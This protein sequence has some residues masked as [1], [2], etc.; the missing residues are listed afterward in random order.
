[1]FHSLLCNDVL[2]ANSCARR[3]KRSRR[4]NS[5]GSVL[6]PELSAFLGTNSMPRTQ[7]VKAMWD[8]IKKNG[9]QV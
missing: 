1:M 5:F 4:S 8:Y 7:V 2:G 9:L 3:P 6:S